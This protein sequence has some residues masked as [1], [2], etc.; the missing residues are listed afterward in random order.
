MIS[1][2]AGGGGRMKELRS[3]DCIVNRVAGCLVLGAW[4]MVNT[5]LFKMKQPATS[6]KQPA[7]SNQHPATLIGKNKLKH[8]TI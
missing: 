7:T 5:A 8:I 1:V 3:A 6:N 4:C 2:Q